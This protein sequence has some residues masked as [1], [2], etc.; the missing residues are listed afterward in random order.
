MKVR[1]APKRAI[2]VIKDDILGVL[3]LITITWENDRYLIDRGIR[4]IVTSSITILIKVERD[5]ALLFSRQMGS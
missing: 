1:D 3:D 5:C 4:G 2:L